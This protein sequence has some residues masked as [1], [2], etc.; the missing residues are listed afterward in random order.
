[1]KIDFPLVADENLSISK[2]YGMIHSA[3]NSTRDVRGVFIIDPNNIIQAEYFYPTSVG[4]NIDELVR[5]VTALERT[6][7]EKVLTPANWK[8]GDDVMV[9]TI[10]KSGA[11]SEELTSE[12]L[13]NL[14]WFMWYKKEK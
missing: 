4:R 5:M 9:P 3:S 1:M 14:A 6:Q 7:S 10:P 2:K 12:G 13:Y 8:A 11:S